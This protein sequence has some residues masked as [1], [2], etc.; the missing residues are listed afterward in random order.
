MKIVVVS[1]VHG[2]NTWKTITRQNPDADLVL[3][4][5]DYIDSDEI[6]ADIQLKNFIEIIEYKKANPGNTILLMGNHEMHYLPSYIMRAEKY[7]KFNELQATEITSLLLNNKHHFRMAF[8]SGNFLFT[9]AGVTEVWLEKNG[10]NEDGDVVGFLNSL[11]ELNPDAYQFVGNDGYGGSVYSSPIWL[12]PPTLMKYG[13]KSDELVQVVG[14]TKHGHVTIN[15]NFIFTDS[16]ASK[17]YLVLNNGIPVI[18]R[19]D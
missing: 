7:V 3:F 5:G 12:R 19:A 6:E 13:Y 11:L 14:H 8:Q 4:I 9:H 10:F 17:E 2:R 1:D 16:P 18:E 15:G